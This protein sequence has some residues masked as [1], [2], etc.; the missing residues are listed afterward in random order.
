[1]TLPSRSPLNPL[2]AALVALL[3]GD[4]AL[5]GLLAKVR[6]ITAPT[7]AVLDDVPEGQAYPYVRIGD[8]TSAADSDLAS[9]G[10]RVTTTLHIWTHARSNGPGQAIATRIG[11]LLDRQDRALSARLAASGHRCVSIR[12]TYDQALDDPDPELR[13]HVLRFVIETA[14]LT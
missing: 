5:S 2:Q 1:M 4:S 14:Q 6:D 10:R 8:H 3:R 13:H 9:H 7:T 12:Q 11:E